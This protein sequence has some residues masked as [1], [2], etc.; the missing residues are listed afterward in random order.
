MGMRG[1]GE[2]VC[3]CLCL[4]GRGLQESISEDEDMLAQVFSYFYSK[5]RGY[6]LP[7]GGVVKGKSK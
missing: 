2:E 1:L 4:C 3:L 7:H 5:N 6:E